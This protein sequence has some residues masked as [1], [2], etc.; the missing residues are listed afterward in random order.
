MIK[1]KKHSL[2]MPVK[3][4]KARMA[5]SS[6]GNLPPNA[7][8]WLSIS[9]VFRT[10]MGGL[11]NNSPRRQSWGNLGHMSWWGWCAILERML[12]MATTYI[13][14]EWGQR[15][16]RSLMTRLWRSSTWTAKMSNFRE[17]WRLRWPPISYFTKNLSLR[18]NDGDV[19]LAIFLTFY[20]T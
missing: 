10:R 15:D 12:S 17:R 4:A 3:S 8:C 18:T 20:I 11:K 2:I 6:R 19:L 1:L 7:R 9:T 5:V 13:M 16:G 14:G